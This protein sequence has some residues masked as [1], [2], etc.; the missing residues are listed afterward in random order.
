MSPGKHEWHGDT[1]EE[2]RQSMREAAEAMNEFNKLQADMGA[3]MLKMKDVTAA[4][5]HLGE[6]LNDAKLLRV[7][8]WGKAEDQNVSAPVGAQEVWSAWNRVLNN[9]GA[10]NQSLMALVGAVARAQA[11][12]GGV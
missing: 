8:I 9:Y 5:V 7:R 10:L 11:R 6:Q 3:L 12:L 2:Q 1:P 4:T